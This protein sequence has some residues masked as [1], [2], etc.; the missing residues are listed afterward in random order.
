MQHF[1]ILY[2]TYFFKNQKTRWSD[3]QLGIEP[4][5]VCYQNLDDIMAHR[6]YR[7]NAE[8][9]INLLSAATLW[10]VVGS[11][12]IWNS[13]FPRF[14][15]NSYFIFVVYL[16]T[17]LHM[18]Q[19]SIQKTKLNSIRDSLLGLIKD[20]LARLNEQKLINIWTDKEKKIFREK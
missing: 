4:M 17:T 13:F 3:V 10:K 5:I 6:L 16:L 11:I 19:S 15:L 1:F 9:Y 2:L 12:P 14:L 7:V 18:F 20:P 8:A